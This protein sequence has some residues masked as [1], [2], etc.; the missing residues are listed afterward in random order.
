[1]EGVTAPPFPPPVFFIVLVIKQYLT[2]PTFEKQARKN[3]SE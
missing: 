3:D 1:M 2:M